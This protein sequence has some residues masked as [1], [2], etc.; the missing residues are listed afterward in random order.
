MAKFPNFQKE[1]YELI[2]VFR[3]VVERADIVFINR[4]KKNNTLTKLARNLVNNVK[5]ESNN[6]E[7]FNNKMAIAKKDM[8]R[9][10]NETVVWLR[11]KNKKEI[12]KIGWLKRIKKILCNDE[13]GEGFEFLC[14]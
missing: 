5:D 11:K 8:E 10:A 9:F 4:G 1:V 3:G 14:D 12:K 13:H 2:K 7:D 6:I